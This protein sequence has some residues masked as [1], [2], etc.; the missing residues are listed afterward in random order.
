[1]TYQKNTNKKSKIF[2]FADDT[3]ININNPIPLAILSKINTILKLI[4]DWF[5]TNLM[6]LN[7]GKSYS[8]QFSTKNISLT[9]F[10]IT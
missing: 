10:N 5:N 8:I 2:I 3:S 9:N 6:S 1:M 7:N 4:D